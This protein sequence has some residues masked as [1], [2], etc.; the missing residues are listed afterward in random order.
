MSLPYRRLG[1]YGAGLVAHAEL[2]SVLIG[3][4]IEA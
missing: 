3:C 2:T 4:S 1:V